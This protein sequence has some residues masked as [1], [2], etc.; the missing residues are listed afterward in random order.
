VFTY[1]LLKI[2]GTPADKPTFRSSE[3]D[4]H[5]GDKVL[6]RPGVEYRIVGLQE[7]PDDRERRL[8]RRVCPERP[9]GTHRRPV[10]FA[11]AAR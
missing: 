10:A 3:C 5:V 11:W 6:I 7:P 1:R 9:T 4:W 8:D 2:D